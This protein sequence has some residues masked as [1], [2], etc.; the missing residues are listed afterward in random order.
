MFCVVECTKPINDVQHMTFVEFNNKV[1]DE[2]ASH[3]VRP[4]FD[5]EIK[6]IMF[7]WVY[8]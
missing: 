2:E 3:M 6:K 7:E 8:I 5:E 4:I 1:S